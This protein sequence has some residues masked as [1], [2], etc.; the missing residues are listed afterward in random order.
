MHITLLQIQSG[1]IEYVITYPDA[2]VSDFM[3]KIIPEKLVL[4]FKGDK[5]KSTIA[6]GK[7]FSTEIVSNQNQNKIEMRLDF[8]AKLIYT[9]LK[10]DEIDKMIASQPDY[11]IEKTSNKDSIIGLLAKEYL[12]ISEN[13]DSKS[14]WFTQDLT[15]KKAYWYSS[16]TKI[17]GVPLI[18]D[19]E[20]YGLKMHIEAVKFTPREVLDSEFDQIHTYSKV[21]FDEYEAEVQGLFDILLK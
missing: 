15:P 1:E 7:I 6:R 19:I 13:G 8:G 2:E 12:I 11:E 20:R 21:N 17:K 14:I 10:E 3:S 5:I 18:Y 16:Y 4:T 9:D